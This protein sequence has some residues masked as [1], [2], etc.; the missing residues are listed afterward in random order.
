M[1]PTAS[2]GQTGINPTSFGT[3]ATKPIGPPKS[4]RPTPKPNPIHL[5]IHPLRKLNRFTRFSP[6]PIHP[7][8]PPIQKSSPSP[9]AAPPSAISAKPSTYPSVKSN[10][11]S[12]AKPPALPPQAYKKPVG[13]N[14]EPPAR[15]G[16]I[17]PPKALET[18][19]I[20]RAPLPKPHR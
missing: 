19:L 14:S 6:K 7:I 5:P 4:L 12:H 20:D 2:I 18:P 10:A 3:P 9:T 8:H 17:T 16:A 15:Y 11:Q 1:G 13:E